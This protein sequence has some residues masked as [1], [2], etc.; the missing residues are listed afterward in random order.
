MSTLINNCH[1]VVGVFFQILLSLILLV[2]VPF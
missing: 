1:M 2:F